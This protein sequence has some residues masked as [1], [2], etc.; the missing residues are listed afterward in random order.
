MN[1]CGF[2][3]GL[4]SQFTDED[5]S[6]VDAEFHFSEWFPLIAPHVRT[7]ETV[8]LT[9]GDLFNGRVDAVLQTPLYGGQCFARLDPCSSKPTRPFTCAREI[10]EHMEASDR[11]GMYLFARGVDADQRCAM[12]LILRKWQPNLGAEFRCFVH[13]KRLRAISSEDHLAQEIVEAVQVILTKITHYAE[14]SDYCADFTLV[15]DAP[16]LTLIEINTPVWLFATSG[17][18]DLSV[19]ADREILMGNYIPDILSYPVIRCQVDDAC[20]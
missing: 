3:H 6:Q 1:T 8:V 16:M 11:T 2:E 15:G 19:V 5:P 4:T 20:V 13:D 17:L 9:W 18:F 10:Q 14:Y 12:P 7:F